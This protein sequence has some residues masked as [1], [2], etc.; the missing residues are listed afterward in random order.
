MKNIIVGHRTL[1][2][3]S[4]IAAT[5]LLSLLV[6]ALCLAYKVDIVRNT[7]R[8]F[9]DMEDNCIYSSD[10]YIVRFSA[11]YDPAQKASHVDYLQRFC[12]LIPDTGPLIVVIDLMDKDVR[13][14][15]VK[16]KFV[17]L[18]ASSTKE[19]YLSII[20]ETA[21]VKP[22]TG[23]IKNKVRFSEAGEYAAYVEIGERQSLDYDMI[24]IPFKISST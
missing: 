11:Y 2:K 6:I 22:T 9:N 3:F 20:E 17:K 5:G 24:V 1:I 23:F 8:L 12:Q 14:L 10:F 7:A 19:K 18:N 15:P 13:A 4:I 21:Y 16:V